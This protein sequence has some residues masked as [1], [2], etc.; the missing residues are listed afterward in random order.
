MTLTCDSTR[1]AILEALDDARA[2]ANRA[3]V[4]V[5]LRACP[6]CAAFARQ[7]QELDVRLSAQLHPPAPSRDLR[8]P[9]RRRIR[10]EA[11]RDWNERLP[12]IV[13]FAGCGAATAIG[14]LLLPVDRWTTVMVGLTGALITYAALA[15]T[16]S[17]L[18]DMDALE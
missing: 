13:H 12:D 16:R 2:A 11:L 9:V 15:M 18:E 8:L 7:Q 3:D 10:R 5:H 17:W 1:T 14:A 6:S 4:D